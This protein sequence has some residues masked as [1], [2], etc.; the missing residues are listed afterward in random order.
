MNNRRGRVEQWRCLC[1]RRGA[2][3]PCNSARPTSKSAAVG[4]PGE[5]TSGRLERDASARLDQRAGDLVIEPGDDGV[6]VLLVKSG[7][8]VMAR[9]PVLPG[10]QPPAVRSC[11]TTSY[12]SRS[13]G[14]SQVFRKHWL[15]KSLA[16]RH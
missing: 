6:R 7:G 16:G 4:L 12:G 2:V 10:M 3:R 13:R 8:A 11:L 5:F 1:I 15:I 14:S 9:L